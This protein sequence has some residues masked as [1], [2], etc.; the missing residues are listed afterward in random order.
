MPILEY[1]NVLLLKPQQD[2]LRSYVH[3]QSYSALELIRQRIVLIW[4]IA[5]MNSVT[6]NSQQDERLASKSICL[7]VS[8]R[9]CCF[10]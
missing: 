7:T 6:V 3:V 10:S 5:S 9:P 1:G 4:Y 2:Y 8:A